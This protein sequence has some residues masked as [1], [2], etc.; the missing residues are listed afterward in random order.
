MGKQTA[1]AYLPWFM[2]LLRPTNR[3]FCSWKISFF[4]V[5]WLLCC[6]SNIWYDIVVSQ[7]LPQKSA[8]LLTIMQ[9]KYA[10]ILG[11][12]WD[13]LTATHNLRQIS[14][15]TRWTC[16]RKTTGSQ[17]VWQFGRIG[18][19]N[20]PKTMSDLYVINWGKWF[21]LESHSKVGR[22]FRWNKS[23]W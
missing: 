11:M 17:D 6:S 21:T 14:V 4:G 15:P 2:I 23:T 7:H 18:W 8:I 22:W 10:S 3:D 1:I 12:V 20:A 9:G 16:K 13:G 19:Q 5:L